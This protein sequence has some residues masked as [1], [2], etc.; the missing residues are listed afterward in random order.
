MK[1]KFNNSIN[2]YITQLIVEWMNKRK[3][4][5]IIE[6]TNKWMNKR[7]IEHKQSHKVAM[8]IFTKADWLRLDLMT[9]EVWANLWLGLILFFLNIP[10]L[11][12]FG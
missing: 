3:N 6:C 2:E 7:I 8:L 9:G 5:L 4:E 12:K 10:F 1:L 11:N